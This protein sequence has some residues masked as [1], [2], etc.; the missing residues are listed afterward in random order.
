MGSDVGDAL[1]DLARALNALG[2]GWYLFGAQAAILY[3]STRVTEDIDVTV[4]LGDLSS[5]ALVSALTSAGFTLRV[6]DVGGFVVRTR[7]LPFVHQRTSMPVD[8]VLSGPGLEESFLARARTHR[9]EGVDIPVASPEDLVVM[10]LLASRPR[11]VEDV[12]SVLK[13]RGADLDVALIRETLRMLEQA[14]DQSDLT[15]AFDRLHREVSGDGPPG[16]AAKPASPRATSMR[17][18]PRGRGG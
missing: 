11:D 4:S 12:R 8:L 1:G 15:P 5:P 6:A 7:V 9:R 10:K 2:V 13:A 18:R 3:G 14:L 17:K 16:A